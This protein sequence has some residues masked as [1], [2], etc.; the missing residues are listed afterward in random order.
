MHQ[1]ARALGTMVGLCE[2]LAVEENRII[3]ADE[4][5]KYGMPLAKAIHT[6]DPES[7]QHWQ[8]T[9]EE[10]LRVFKAAG[11]KK[12]WH[13]P[14]GGQHIMGGT[15]MG[16]D[17]ATSVTN[18]NAQTH[19]IPNLIIGGGGVFPTSSCVNSTFTIHAVAMKSARYLTEHW[20]EIVI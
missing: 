1:G 2:D 19:D 8:Q 10:G 18:E 6:V 5:D 12:A 15:I 11:A 13:S 9:S 7:R 16:N 20:S 14:P 4:K 3:L 17:P